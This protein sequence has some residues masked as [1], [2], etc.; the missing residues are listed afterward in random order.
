VDPSPMDGREWVH[1]M[2]PDG[3]ASLAVSPSHNGP[4]QNSRA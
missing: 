1:G 3:V 4:N 2:K